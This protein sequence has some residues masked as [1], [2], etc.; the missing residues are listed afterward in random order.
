[1]SLINICPLCI[2]DIIVI[3]IHLSHNNSQWQCNCSQMC[4]SSYLAC[5]CIC[6]CVHST[7]KGELEGFFKGYGILSSGI[8][9]TYETTLMRTHSY[10]VTECQT[11]ARMDIYVNIS[12]MN[13]CA[14]YVC[15][16]WVARQPPGFGF[17]EFEVYTHSQFM[18]TCCIILY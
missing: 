9:H 12:V 7:T 8:R 11:F 15:S 17:V 10:C 3:S 13:V 18:I 6:V 14:C 2:M 5:V 16:V 1:M 4:A